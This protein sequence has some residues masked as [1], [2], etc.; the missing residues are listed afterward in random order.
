MKVKVYNSLSGILDIRTLGELLEYAEVLIFQYGSDA[1]YGCHSYDIDEYVVTFRDETPSERKIRECTDN[2]YIIL[3]GN[4]CKT[5]HNEVISEI[6]YEKYR[7]VI[8]NL[9][10]V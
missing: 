5:D 2:A 6:G 9:N 1:E 7:T 4:S 3:K 10:G 8:N